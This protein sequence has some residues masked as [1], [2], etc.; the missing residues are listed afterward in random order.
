MEKRENKS[1]LKTML[2]VFLLLIAI[3]NFTL[4]IVFKENINDFTTTFIGESILIIFTFMYCLFLFTHKTKNNSIINFASIILI[5]FFLF[6]I[7][8]RF[9]VDSIDSI[10]PVNFTNKSIAEVIKWSEKNK[11]SIDQIYEYSDLIPENKVIAQSKYDNINKH[12]T[13]KIAVS[14]GP[15][16]TKEVILPDMTNWDVEKVVKQVKKDYL[17]NIVVDF[18]ESDKKENTVISQSK[19]GT[20]KRDDEILI[21]FSLGEHFEEKEIILRDLQEMDRIDVLIYLKQNRLEY[22]FNDDFDK[23]IGKGK[24]IRQDVSAGSTVKP[25]DK[26]VITL[27][28]GKEIIVPNL[29]KMSIKEIS[30]WAIKNKL[31][32]EFDYKYDEKIKKNKIISVNYNYKDKIK[33]KETLKITLSNG[34][35]KMPKFN[36]LDDFYTWVTKYNIPYQEEHEFSDEVKQGEVI[37]YSYKP[38]EVIKNDDTIIVKISDGKKIEMPNLVGLSKSEAESKLSKLKINY[39]LTYTASNKAK[40]TVIAQSIAAGSKTS[41]N[42]TVNLTISSGEKKETASSSNKN[43]NSNNSSSNS[44]TPSTNTNTPS[45]PPSNT[46]TPSTNTVVYLY[47]ELYDFTNPSGTCNKVKSTYPNVKFTCQYKSGTGITKG[48]VINSGAIDSKT[49]TN[50]DTVVLQISE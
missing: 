8:N 28:K 43:Y 32:L 15:N 30:N 1:I 48:M 42:I 23:K 6:N 3:T 5:I 13:L 18:N 34:K 35:L 31:R 25:G 39:T 44:T 37:S 41:A 19:T 38:G 33:E 21:T 17:S 47:E 10:K 2:L 24:V 7:N 20:V 50:C 11:I 9:G 29:K 27:S 46:C 14:D 45:T 4:C 16:P 26:I 49:F 36:T 40:N 22:E 12:D